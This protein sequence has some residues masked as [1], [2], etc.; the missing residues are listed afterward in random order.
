MKAHFN[1]IIQD[2]DKYIYEYHVLKH[3][4]FKSSFG[5]LALAGV[6]GSLK[7]VNERG[8]LALIPFW[9]LIYLISKIYDFVAK[10]WFHSGKSVK[11]KFISHLPHYWFPDIL[12]MLKC[13]NQNYRLGEIIAN[14]TENWSDDEIDIKIGKLSAIKINRANLSNFVLDK[15][16][17]DQENLKKNGVFVLGRTTL[18]WECPKDN[19]WFHYFVLF[20]KLFFTNL[21]GI[22]IISSIRNNNI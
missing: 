11:L 22:K 6:L 17:D 19:Y 12:W 1:S 7:V 13:T 18:I 4:N 9:I 20:I 14:A 15:A 16:V 8:W 21:I 3:D 2:G 5:I 10:K